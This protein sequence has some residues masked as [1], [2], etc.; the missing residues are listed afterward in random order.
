MGCLQ[1]PALLWGLKTPGFS[2]NSLWPALVCALLVPTPPTQLSLH[3][4]VTPAQSPA[5][6]IALLA[7]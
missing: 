6:L 3:P 1:I 4:P 5:S 2:A 7:P